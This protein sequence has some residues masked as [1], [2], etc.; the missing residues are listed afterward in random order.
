MSLAQQPYI[1]Q[2][3]LPAVD[4][5]EISCAQALGSE[6]YVGCTNGSLLR[7][8]I[9]VGPD[10][11]ESYSL[12]SRQSLPNSKPI[13][14]LVL[15]PYLARVLILSDRQIHFY[16]I[17]SLDPIP[18]VKPIRNVN[19]FTVDQQH[20]LRPLPSSHDPHIRLQPVDFCVIKRISISL[21]SLSEERLQFHKDIPFQPGTRLA[22]QT[23][24]YLCIAD[25]ENYNVVDMQ[26]SQMISLLPVSQAIDSVVP[27][28]PFILVVSENEFLI[29]SWTG[30]STIGI[31][32]TGEGDPVR[33]T[34][35]FPS[36]P[37]SICLDH[38]NVTALLANGSIEVHEIETQSIV[39]VIPPP[40]ENEPEQ[41][42]RVGIVSSVGGYVVPSQEYGNKLRK[43][44][45]R[46]RRG[47][48]PVDFDA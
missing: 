11:Q 15:I 12:S 4:S 7:Y 6:I 25:A 18:N 41:G 45:V 29:L 19:M 44:K 39:Q 38:P 37:L 13:D 3:V 32:I 1:L 47:P 17:P 24:H 9:H 27:V 46:L 16:S 30:T 43:M 2:P 35:T 33:G 20:L 48:D 42:R 23:G 8:T 34:L 21:F 36:H 22:R 28:K 10:Q 5:G 31:F 26:N 40:P 14:E